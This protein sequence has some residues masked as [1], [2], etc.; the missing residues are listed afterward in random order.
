MADID[1]PEKSSNK[2]S[3]DMNADEMAAFKK[4]MGEIEGQEKENLN[5]TANGVGTGEKDDQALTEDELAKLNEEIEAHNSES[6]TGTDISD[7]T[8]A[9][10][11]PSEDG[12][13]ESL[14]QDQQKAFESI[15]AQIEGNGEADEDTDSDKAIGDGPDPEPANDFSAELEKVVQEVDAAEH[16]Q[17]QD[18]DRTESDDA[19]E[20]DP[21]KAFESITAQIEDGDIVQ[22]ES[23]SVKSVST[24][25]KVAE[26]SE[27]QEKNAAG[28]SNDKKDMGSQDIS[29]DI[30]DILKEVTSSDDESHLPET[31]ANDPVSE[32]ADVATIEKTIVD[33]DIVVH[34]E[35]DRGPEHEDSPQTS[36]PAGKNGKPAEPEEKPSAKDRSGQ[37]LA[38]TKPTPAALQSPKKSKPLREAAKLAGGGRKKAILASVA[39][40]LFITLAGYFYWTQKGTIDSKAT[41]P[42]TD[43]RRQDAVVQTEPAPQPQ[44]SVV[45]VYGPS[46]QSRLKTAAEKLDRLRNEL[47]EKQAEIEELRAYYQAGIDAEIKGI[48]NTVRKTGKGTIPFNAAMTAPR[49]SLGLSAIQRRDSYIKKL[50]TPAKSLFWNSETLLFLSRKAGLLALMAGKTSDIDIDGFIKQADEIRDAHGSALAQ[51][52]IDAVT[53]SPLALESIWQDIEKRLATTPVKREK[54]NTATETD[55]AAIWKNICNG[56]FTRKHKLAALSPE[57]ARCLATWKGKDLFLNELT[58]LSPETA[59]QLAAWE[60]DWLGLNGLKELSP[61]AAM[62]LSR[63]KGKGLSLNGLSRLSPRV[64]AILSE[65]QGDQI[66]LINVKHM[67]RWENPK[68]RLFL[69]EDLSRKLNATRK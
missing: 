49:I 1:H 17:T 35:E 21:Q 46:D 47:I 69:S 56:D 9:E 37:P 43:T 52:N 19:L 62:H 4:I 5:G 40:I 59:R 10:T 16:N 58:D 8:T 25:A 55:N 63:W 24:D 11:P 61:E 6:P 7:S 18:A 48:V 28:S 12:D 67:A 33:D 20:G 14:D 42:V 57:T 54:N 32:P 23:N 38:D 29:D 68:T 34:K 41:S 3:D 60:G 27:D 2:S 26:T 50:V 65:W 44:E 22:A 45:V 53:T 64:V 51:L 66:E 36:P 30:D 13:D 39:V 15:M 31:A